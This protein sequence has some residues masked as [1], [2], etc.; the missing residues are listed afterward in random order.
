MPLAEAQSHWVADLLQGRA[1]LP[2]QPE[3]NREIAAYRG[4][5]ARR[6]AR[7]ARH[8]IQVDFLPYL[9]EIRAERQAGARRG[10]AGR[11]LARSPS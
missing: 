9:S 1:V 7:S 8:L 4:A 5:T 11:K 10:R 6:Y 3:M 2:P